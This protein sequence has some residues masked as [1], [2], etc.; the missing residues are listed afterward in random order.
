MTKIAQRGSYR[1]LAGFLLAVAG[2]LMARPTCGADF[3][4]GG[5]GTTN[6][7]GNSTNWAL[8]LIPPTSGINTNVFME[9][10]GGTSNLA[11]IF[12]NKADW[13]ITSL[14]FNA[15]T[16][17]TW[18]L[19][20]GKLTVDGFINNKDNQLQAFSNEQVDLGSGLQVSLLASS[21]DLEF[22]APVH[23]LSTQT[24]IVGGGNTVF[25]DGSITAEPGL[26]T[27]RMR[28]NDGTLARISSDASALE[29]VEILDGTLQMGATGVFS[30]G[31]TRINVS[32]GSIFDLDSRNTNVGAVHGAGTILLGGATLA[33][34]DIFT[35]TFSG[36][37]QESGT[38]IKNGAGTLV[39]SG[40]NNTMTTLQISEGIVQVTNPGAFGSNTSIGTGTL[41][42]TATMTSGAPIT[43]N[44][45][46]STIDVNNTTTFTQSGI[47]S[48]SGN[49][50]KEGNG[51]LVLSAANTY[52]GSTEI[53]DGTLRLSAANRINDNSAI[54]LPAGA[55]LE[56]NNFS[57]TVKTIGNISGAGGTVDT[58]GSGGRLTLNNV[59]GTST[60]GGTFTGSGG[61]DK[62][63]GHTLII[64]GNNTNSGATNITGGTL[65]LSGS[66][67]LGNDSDVTF[68]NATWDLNNISDTVDSISGNGLILL[69]SAL[70]TMD[71]ATATS[72]TF[73][74]NIHG[75]GGLRKN[76]AHTLVLGGNNSFSGEL[77][78]AEGTL[79]VSASVNLGAANSSL[80]F[81]GGTLQSTAT[82]SNPRS[83]FI[84]PFASANFNVNTATTLT[85]SGAFTGDSTTTLS[86]IG[87][88]TLRLTGAS[89]AT[90]T[91]DV[92]VSDGT[93]D[94]AGP[95]G[96]TLGT[97]TKVTTN[98]SGFLFLN[99]P[100][101]LGGL[102]GSGT[103][104]L[105]QP[106]NV[107]FD[108]ASTT[109]SGSISG[110]AGFGKRGTGTLTLSGANSYAGPT[111][112][113]AGTLIA[114]GSNRLPT[115]TDLSISLG[116]NV[117]LTSEVL[118]SLTGGGNLA[119]GGFSTLIIGNGN[120]SGTFSG[121]ISD[122]TIATLAKAGT[123][124]QVLSGNNSYTTTQFR[125][126]KLTT[127]ASNNL[128]TGSLQFGGGTW[129]VAG[130]FTNSRPTNLGILGFPFAGTFDI[131]P[132]Q[133]LTQS[134]PITGSN[135]Q[136]DLTKTDNGTL[137]LTAP[138]TY[139]GETN[140]DSGTV[141]LAGSGQLPDTTDVTFGGG[142]IWD[143][144][145][146][147]DTVATIAG[148]GE[149]Q[150]SG[151][152]A[153][154]L[155][156]VSGNTIFSG[157]ISG[158]GILNKAGNHRLRLSGTNTYIA[159][160]RINGGILEID[161]DANLGNLGS[162]LFINNGILQTDLSLT[163]NRNVYLDADYGT[164]HTSGGTNNTAISG[165]VEGAGTLIKSGN[166][167]AGSLSLSGSNIYTGGTIVEAGTL[168]V[169]SNLNL[170]ANSGSVTLVDN[171][172]LEATGTFTNQHAIV[173]DNSGE[174]SVLS[175][176]TLTQAVGISGTGIF[177]KTGP[178]E[179]LLNAS[180]TNIGGIDLLD[181]TLGGNGSVSGGV[182][183]SLGTTLAPGTPTIASTAVMT[184]GSLLIP[185]G[186]RYAVDLA[187]DGGVS[188][189]D[190]DRIVVNNLASINDAT[191]GVN[192][193]N[194]YIPSMGDQYQILKFSGVVSG[195]GFA[196]FELPALSSGLAWQTGDLLST[197]VLSVVAELPGDFDIDGD[198]D[199]RDF[200]L[201]QRD[202]NIGLL[203]DWQSNYGITL[204]AAAST[205]V[206]E[207]TSWV[208]M[209]LSIMG[210]KFA[211]W[212]R[213]S[214]L[215]SFLGA[216]KARISRPSCLRVWATGIPGARIA[217]VS[218]SV[219]FPN[220]FS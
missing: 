3:T 64:T 48:G 56:L 212:R 152:S 94:L 137:I 7:W 113:S 81:F 122:S 31:G 71:E 102:A 163:I 120:G 115:N 5:G 57:E 136:G 153:L 79:S 168:S 192:L 6:N 158:T 129:E 130:T 159:G 184:V 36:N 127:A 40:T 90:F 196:T 75:T 76:G 117:Q 73:I 204:L 43:V 169:S 77:S 100:T 10:L 146:I 86:K 63:G 134:A 164:I 147:N 39:L 87:S 144:N 195:S 133:T 34:E 138:N 19:I 109:Y 66:G 155:A 185:A 82:F 198:V 175:G 84:G 72:R 21:G 220:S 110:A 44:S 27:T 98:F 111:S 148:S 69:G 45:F 116:A 213:V 162:P 202:P 92:T 188:G 46:T 154:T 121:V 150:L 179:L 145:G 26:P 18:N 47:I 182:N 108:N 131:N 2:G 201:W 80:V 181:G 13:H 219:V 58:G 1:L 55:T 28:I 123:G 194:G 37:I 161:R 197:G 139:G 32:S 190:F 135:G 207:P 91:G 41:Q 189:T 166:A 8:G 200:L 160:T 106:L 89:A 141:Q 149:I 23:F 54:N 17:G 128:G 101:D 70:L 205:S 157:V 217:S 93:L 171:S 177:T 156:A 183:L 24:M 167:T 218:E 12:S 15:A 35:R 49:L 22:N 85:Q 4:W 107:G 173:L 174:I 208:L 210:W 124:A 118:D 61:F 29:I 206:P 83:T 165:I 216:R 20:G 209:L 11:D 119:I 143:L 203:A 65:Q 97:S 176:Q 140:I 88:G 211:N 103:I 50:R 95:S 142:S 214:S 114:S 178:G 126:G 59:I 9:G 30:L 96:T 105:N 25:F 51:T 191:L 16:T 193:L 78:I 53:L 112:V 125:G 52:T 172:R 186:A 180:A 215:E 38:V 199:G 99:S 187:G 67:S 132:G 42:T 68:F 14:T 170:G 74:G 60:F 33:I 62:Q 104:V 151:Q